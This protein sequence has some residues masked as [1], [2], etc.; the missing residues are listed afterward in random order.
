MDLTL[1][2]WHTHRLEAPPHR[3][4]INLPMEALLCP[5]QFRFRE[6]CLYSAGIH[7]LYDGDWEKAFSGLQWLSEQGR[8]YAIG[9]CGLDRPNRDLFP[10]QCAF[11]EKQMALAQEKALPLIVHCVGHW[12]V[13][14]RLHRKYPSDKLRLVHGFRG[15]PELAR[16]LLAAGFSL[17][18]GLRYNEQSFLLCPSCRRRMETDDEHCSIEQVA[19]K[20][21]DTISRA[22]SIG[23]D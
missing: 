5:R 14:L 9:E 3:A 22:C 16:Q 19:E 12:E 23:N 2:D 10:K 6:D 20:Q 4:V 8:L 17:G 21:N 1:F 15:K 18:F 13:L 7:P 11:F